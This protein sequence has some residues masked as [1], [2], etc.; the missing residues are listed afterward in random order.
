GG[1]RARNI[2]GPAGPPAVIGR[3]LAPCGHGPDGGSASGDHAVDGRDLSGR[4]RGVPP[5]NLDRAE[6]HKSTGETTP[7]RGSARTCALDRRC[8]REE[9]RP[10]A[11][12]LTFR[13]Y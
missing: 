10:V 3:R 11:L 8:V 2:D 9:A 12:K 6:G 5:G 13:K 1:R 4:R 7:R